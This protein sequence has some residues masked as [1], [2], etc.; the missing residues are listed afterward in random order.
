MGQRLIALAK[1]K[2]P[3]EVGG[4][5]VPDLRGYYYDA[6]LQWPAY[7]LAGFHLAETGFSLHQIKAG[8]FKSVPFLP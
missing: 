3:T 8:A 1:F 6:Q 7:W 2:L 4:H 5:E